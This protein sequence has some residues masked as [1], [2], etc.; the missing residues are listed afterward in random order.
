MS[1][2]SRFRAAAQ[3][4]LDGGGPSIVIGRSDRY[5]GSQMLAPTI[6]GLAD[7]ASRHDDRE[8]RAAEE[9]L[10]ND[11]FESFRRTYLRGLVELAGE[12]K[13][14]PQQAPKPSPPQRP[15]A[16]APAVDAP[17]SKSLAASEV[18]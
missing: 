10:L 12:Q 6:N 9:K 11:A 2:D 16:P 17:R 3:R 8:G 5:S 18:I 7:L 15:Q 1:E 13:Q 4:C 14:E